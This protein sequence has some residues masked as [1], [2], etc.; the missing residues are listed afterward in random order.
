MAIIGN[1]YII[2][3]NLIWPDNSIFNDLKQY[4]LDGPFKSEEIAIQS[5]NDN[6]SSYLATLN[7][8][9]KGNSLTILFIWNDS[10]GC[11]L[12]IKVS[13]LGEEY[14]YGWIFAGAGNR[15]GR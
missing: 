7:E 10:N 4:K 2:S 15:R 6:S 8:K 12:D 5:L 13:I 1:V 14:G 11:D 3:S 9:C